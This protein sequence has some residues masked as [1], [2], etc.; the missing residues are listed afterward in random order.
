MTVIGILFAVIGGIGYWWWRGRAAADAVAVT[1]DAAETLRGAYNRRKFRNNVEGSHLTA[2]DDPGTAVAATM[3]CLASLRGPI[4]A[5]AESAMKDDYL[6]VVGAPLTDDIFIHCKWI[7]D[8]TADPNDM[9]RKFAP[10]WKARLHP[11]ERADVLVLA[12]RAASFDGAP[13]DAQTRAL[14]YLKT[15]LHIF[16]KNAVPRW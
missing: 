12:T 2:V 16:P 14:G 9:A 11:S 13:T 4:S 5:A 10:L 1:V 8:Q 15:R 3:I 6:E 7:A